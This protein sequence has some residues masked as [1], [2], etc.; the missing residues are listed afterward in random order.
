VPKTKATGGVDHAGRSAV[1]KMFKKA[2]HE[3]FIII[4]ISSNLTMDVENNKIAVDTIESFCPSYWELFNPDNYL[5]Y[6]RSKEKNS[7]ENAEKL[8]ESIEDLIRVYPDFP[9]VK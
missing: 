8:Y 5:I 2:V 6:F 4:A 7:S 3:N 9:T 1:K